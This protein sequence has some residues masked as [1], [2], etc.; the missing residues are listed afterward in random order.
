MNSALIAT[1]RM[2]LQGREKLALDYALEVNEYWGKLSAEGKSSEPEMFFFSDRGMWM[3]KGT[4]D[5]LWQ[6]LE[7]DESQRMMAQGNLLLGDFAYEFVK[8]GNAASEH[9]LRCAGVG[10]ELSLI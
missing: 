4:P 6:I 10:Q 5:A 2:P 8:T 1:W 7:A 3:V 9:L